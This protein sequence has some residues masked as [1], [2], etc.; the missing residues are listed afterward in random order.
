MLVFPNPSNTSLQVALEGMGTLDCAFTI[1]DMV[2]SSI[3]TG[4]LPESRQ[5]DVAQLPAGNYLLMVTG[6]DQP[7]WAK[8]QK[9]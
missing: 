9:Q 2:G 4:H 5:I 8:F 7:H 1:Y 6:L 3:V